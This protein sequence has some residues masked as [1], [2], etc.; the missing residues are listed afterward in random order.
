MRNNISLEAAEV[1]D[2]K[3]A[4]KNFA[5]FTGKRRCFP[6][7]IAKFLRTT[8]A[9]VSSGNGELVKVFYA[10]KQP[11]LDLNKDAKNIDE[12]II[13]EG[14]AAIKLVEKKERERRVVNNF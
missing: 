14:R 7:N 9:Y 3:A 4:L 10:I 5:I 8:D 6:V 12:L 11:S 1:F 2:K 13:S